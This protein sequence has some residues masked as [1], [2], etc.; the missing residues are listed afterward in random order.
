M[1]KLS[2]LGIPKNL[3]HIWIGP[4]RPPV[5]WMQ[6]WQDY[7]PDWSYTLYDNSFAATYPFRNKSLITE[8][9]KRSQFAGA[10][11]LMRYE[12]L[13]DFG[14]FL[15]EADSVCLAN[16]DHLFE[17]DCAYTVY[18]N[19]KARPGMVSPILACP[20]GNKFVGQLID[21]LSTLRPRELGQPWKTTGNRFVASMIQKYDPQIT[22]FPS[23]YFIPEHFSGE[24]YTGP[25]QVF[26]KQL[27]G[28]TTDAYGS[29]SAG[30]KARLMTGKI[31]GAVMRRLFKRKDLK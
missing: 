21:E 1:T 2:K 31:R 10:A 19:E 30:T 18:E 7:H 9:L 20:P 3:G 16:T 24:K 22:I 8:Y 13:Y 23:H 15:P 27:F 6:T 5:D 14:G 29:V 25:D 17:H 4:Y 12:I 28:S 11:D 26:A